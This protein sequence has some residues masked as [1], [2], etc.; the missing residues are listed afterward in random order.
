M[1]AII[2]KYHGQGNVRGPRISASDMD[3]NRVSIPYP[4]HLPSD[5]AHNLAAITLCNKMNWHGTVYG[6][7][8][9]SGNVYV[10][11]DEREKFAV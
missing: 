1:K 4:D 10:F 11:A 6:G 5:K 2:T 8:I 7:G 9:K 3:G